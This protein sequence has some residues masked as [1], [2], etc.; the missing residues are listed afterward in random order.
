MSPTLKDK[1]K[2]FADLHTREGIFVMPNAWDEGSAKFLAAQGFPALAT[3]SGGVNWARGREDYV[4]AVPADEMMEAYGRV[5]DCVD[6]PVSGDLEDGYATEPEKVAETIRRA[7]SLGMVGGGIEDFTGDE[8]KP[9]YDVQ[10]AVERIRAAR[11]AAD[12]ADFPFTLTARCENFYFDIKDK[13]AEAVKRANL[14]REAGADCLFLPGGN[15]PEIIQSLVR[16]IDAPLNVVAEWEGPQYTVP[17]LE[18]MEVRRIS[19][20]GSMARACYATLQQAAEKLATEGTFGYL[21]NVISD[22]AMSAFFKHPDKANL[23]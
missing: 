11:M 1:A 12:E 13:Y 19:T 18:D 3:T 9:L 4:C 5:A 14:Y 15:T 20:G 2:L 10:L 8:E 23:A 22:P 6:V 21:G 16:E 17:Q 7:A